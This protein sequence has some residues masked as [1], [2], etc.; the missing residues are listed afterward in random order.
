M[1]E[2]NLKRFEGW[3]PM[4]AEKGPPLPRSMKVYWPWVTPSPEEVESEC[5]IDV[6]YHVD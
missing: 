1:A 6:I 4:P 2:Q 5:Y 3:I